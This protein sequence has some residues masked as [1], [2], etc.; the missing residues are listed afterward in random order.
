MDLGQVGERWHH[1]ME[2][3]KATSESGPV[4][5]YRTVLVNL[6]QIGPSEKVKL[7]IVLP[8]PLPSTEVL[9][10][11]TL[12][13]NHLLCDLFMPQEREADSWNLTETIT[14]TAALAFAFLQDLVEESLAH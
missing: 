3:I 11:Y 8:F 12:R 4:I 10:N 2:L 1:F 9:G 14:L 5:M 6:L 7:L 13:E